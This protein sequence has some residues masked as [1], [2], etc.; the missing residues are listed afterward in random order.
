M[1]L[2]NWKEKYY[3]E[4]S[5]QLQTGPWSYAHDAIWH[6]PTSNKKIDQQSHV[7]TQTKHLNEKIQIERID[8]VLY[9]MVLW[10]NL[11]QSVNAQA[12]M[13]KR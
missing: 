13:P 2:L 4:S 7:N 10:Y 5:L 8:K 6:I 9:E 11:V 3:V 1:F 12:L